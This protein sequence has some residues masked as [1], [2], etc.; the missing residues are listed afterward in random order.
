MWTATGGVGFLNAWVDFNRDGDWSDAGEQVFTSELLAMGVNSLSF[1][2]PATA[3]ADS[4]APTISR[5]RFSRQMVLEVGGLSSSGEVEDHAVYIYAAQPAPVV[6]SLPWEWD[7]AFTALDA[8]GNRQGEPRMVNLAGEVGI[9]YAAPIVQSTAQTFDLLAP[10]NDARGRAGARQNFDFKGEL[11]GIEPS[12]ALP[13]VD[14]EVLVAFEHGDIRRPVVIGSLWF[15]R[16]GSLALPRV[17][18]VGDARRF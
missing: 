6:A 5:W 16:S 18:W 1:P 15:E 12:F 7:L 3:L 2:V 14:D 11:V 8:E 13:E 17:G 4:A 9:E 10:R